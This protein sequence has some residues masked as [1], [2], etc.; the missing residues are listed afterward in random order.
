[1]FAVLETVT[2]P[3][4]RGWLR[5]SHRLSAREKPSYLSVTLELPL[6]MREARLR[7]RV[8]KALRAAKKSGSNGIVLPKGFPFPELP[9][10][11]DLAVSSPVPLLRRLAAHL[12]RFAV[13]GN[14]VPWEKVRLSLIGRRSTP[15]MLAAAQQLAPLT[16]ALH[17]EAGGDT[18]AVCYFLRG[19]YGLSAA[20][21]P[22]KT[23]DGV[24]DV[25]LLFSAEGR[26]AVPQDALVLNLTGGIPAVSGGRVADGAVLDPPRQ[27]RK[28]WP[29]GCDDG[30]LLAALLAT[31]QITLSDVGIR[32]LTYRD[33]LI[34]F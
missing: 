26:F 21:R 22:A 20:G 8:L 7:K 15:E 33:S 12:C 9:G 23:E 27:M 34:K 17:I 5:N 3:E 6:N 1:M 31:G 19:R 2:V 25:V 11:V 32:G 13:E 14:G 4:R 16:G 28:E 18:E 24:Y 29:P 30:A 10:Q